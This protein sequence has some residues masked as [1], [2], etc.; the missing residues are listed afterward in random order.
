MASN[1]TPAPKPKKT[2]AELAAIKA[3]KGSKFKEIGRK[4]MTVAIA[5]I[6]LI[7]NLANKQSYDF[8]PDDVKKMIDALDATTAKVEA[9]FKA[10]LDGIKTADAGAFDF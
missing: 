8:T 4:R 9:R 10:A 3:A 5:K 2:D 7:G 6:A 1:V